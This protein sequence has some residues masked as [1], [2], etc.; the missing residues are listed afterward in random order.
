MKKIK[1]E[2]FV[3]IQP[4]KPYY[5]L[6]ITK[7]TKIKFNNQFVKQKIE[8]LKLYTTRIV[9]TPE[10]ISKTIIEINLNEGDIVLLEEENRGFFLPR[11]IRFG[12]IKDLEAEIEFGKEQISKIKE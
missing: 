2:V 1:K 10:F 4:V 8:D 11:D 6:R 3:E 9:K 12:T 7:D 5:G